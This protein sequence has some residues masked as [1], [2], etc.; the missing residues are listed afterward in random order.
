MIINII[1]E[2]RTLFQLP[3]VQ[4]VPR[5]LLVNFL[6]KQFLDTIKEEVFYC[7]GKRFASE[8]RHVVML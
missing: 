8:T 4:E 2:D 6:P 5:N 3:L 1:L 7:K